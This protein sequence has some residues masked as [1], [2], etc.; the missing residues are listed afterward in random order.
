MGQL[1]FNFPIDQFAYLISH[2]LWH[3]EIHHRLVITPNRTPCI[4]QCRHKIRSDVINLSSI[5]SHA[6]HNILN[7]RVIKLQ[8]LRLNQS[9]W[10]FLARYKNRI[11]FSNHCFKNEIK[12]TT[13]VFIQPSLDILIEIRNIHCTCEL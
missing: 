12:D 6:V 10:I 3:I 13:D 7:M 4:K 8:K 11:L 5:L 1:E 2:K 9:C